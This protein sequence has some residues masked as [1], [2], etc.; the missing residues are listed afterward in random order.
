M[1]GPGGRARLDGGIPAPQARA[2]EFRILV[3]HSMDAHVEPLPAVHEQVD[4]VEPGVVQHV[5]HSN[6]THQVGHLHSSCGRWEEGRQHPRAPAER[7]W[8]GGRRGGAGGS[9]A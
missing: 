4:P 3:V 8:R 1:D 6:R 7:P 9:A 2:Q 5:Q